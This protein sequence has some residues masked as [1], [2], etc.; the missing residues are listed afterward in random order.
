MFGE[1]HLVSLLSLFDAL[2]VCALLA[3]LSLRVIGS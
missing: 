3:T 2:A 1:R